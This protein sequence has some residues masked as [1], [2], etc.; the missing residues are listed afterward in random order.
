M[1]EA[2]RAL[3]TH[4]VTAHGIEA[5]ASSV[6]ADNPA[7]LRVQEKLGFKVTGVGQTWCR[8]RDATVAT[9]TTRLASDDF[10]GAT[11]VAKPAA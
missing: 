10:V 8:P 3:I 6:F 11:A 2:A 7:S 9:L 1:T 4:A 5:I